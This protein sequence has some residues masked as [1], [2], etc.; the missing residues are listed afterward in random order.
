MV[1][2]AKPLT[3]WKASKDSGRG[4]STSYY[5]ETSEREYEFDGEP[6]ELKSVLKGGQYIVAP[7][8]AKQTG[9]GAEKI[10]AETYLKLCDIDV[11]FPTKVLFVPS[12]EK[13]R[14]T[15][16]ARKMKLDEEEFVRFSLRKFQ[17]LMKQAPSD[18]VDAIKGS[19]RDL[20]ET[21]RSSG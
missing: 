5:A 14:T 3:D 11:W 13:L 9:F 15:V 12:W 17:E 10:D 19:E 6:A 4:V 21:L 1:A 7:P 18:L 2:G 8:G 16:V 20:S